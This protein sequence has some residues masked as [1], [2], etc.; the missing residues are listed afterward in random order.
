LVDMWNVSGV[1]DG[2]EFKGLKVRLKF[3]GR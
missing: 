2:A 3:I 1:P